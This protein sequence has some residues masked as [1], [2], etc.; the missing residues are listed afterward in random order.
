MTRKKFAMLCASALVLLYTYDVMTS[1][2][3]GTDVK[4][5]SLVGLAL[6]LGLLVAEIKS[7]E[8]DTHPE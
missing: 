5:L 8:N 1:V 6:A 4:I 3:G 2:V 7:V